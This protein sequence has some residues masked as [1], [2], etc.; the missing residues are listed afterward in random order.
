MNYK[1]FQKQNNMSAGKI[2][3]GVLAG[4]AAG[5]AIG[6]LFAPEKGS[7]TRKKILG[8]ANDLAE[9][10]KEKISES[11]KD[12]SNQFESTKDDL[13]DYAEAGKSR[14]KSNYKNF[15]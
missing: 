10:I 12:V 7:A 2:V 1:Q 14:V 6:I 3:L 9:D 15:N 11:I 8:I 5:A 13:K 4:F